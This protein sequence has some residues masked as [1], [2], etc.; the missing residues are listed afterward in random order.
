MKLPRSKNPSV[1]LTLVELLVVVALLGVIGLFLYPQLR[2]HRLPRSPR[3]NCVNNLKQVALGFQLWAG[4]ARYPTVVS[5]NL[6]GALEYVTNGDVFWGFKVMSNELATPKILVCPT[7][8]RLAATSFTTG[9][10][11]TNI[12]YFVGL[13]ADASNPQMWLAGDRNIVSGQQPTN[14]ILTLTS[15]DVV[16]WTRAMH[17]LQGNVAIADGHVDQ[18]STRGLQQALRSSGAVTNRLALP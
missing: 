12:S 13:D 8:T 7:D 14:R 15:N 16:S 3:I 4:T 5:T 6:G 1:A 2:R 17:K 9:F 11:N 10:S 18:L